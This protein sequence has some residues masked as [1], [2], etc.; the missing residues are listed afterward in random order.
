MPATS[1]SCQE[2]SDLSAHNAARIDLLVS[3]VDSRMSN[4]EEALRTAISLLTSRGSQAAS[5]SPV[6]L[7]H[8]SAVGSSTATLT[9]T[10]FPPSTMPPPVVAPPTI[11]DHLDVNSQAPH[12]VPSSTAS[13]TGS[14]TSDSSRPSRSSAHNKERD[15]SRASSRGSVFSPDRHRSRSSSRRRRHGKAGKYDAKYFLDEGEKLN[16]YERLS[17]VNLRILSR[18]FRKGKDIQGFLDHC[19]LL[20]EKAD[21]GLF[22]PETLIKY[23]NHVKCVAAEKGSASFEKIDP[24]SIVKFLSYDGTKGAEKQA[25]NHSARKSRSSI[26]P[27]GT[28]FRFNFSIDGCKR[29]SCPYKHVCSTCFSASHIANDCSRKSEAKSSISK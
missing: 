2:Q 18:M 10:T 19:I 15:S 3:S 23:D 16:S 17:L 27:N 22:R 11:Q 12:H 13:S 9:A 21:P 7:A 29:S 14:I 28:C 4:V 8:P 24:A 1:T 5:P 6:G 25:S 20:A 26:T